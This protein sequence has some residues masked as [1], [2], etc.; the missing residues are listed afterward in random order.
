M[1]KQSST[2]EKVFQTADELLAQ[3]VRPTQQNVR[4][5]IGSGSLTTINSALN[6][7]WQ[8]LSQRITRQ[9]AHPDLPEPVVRLAS[10]AWDR[11]LAYAEQA[12][13][14]RQL[15][16]LQKQADLESSLSQTVQGSSKA[17]SDLQQQ[18]GQL[19][20]RFARMTE[21]KQS[22]EEQ[23]FKLEE[24]V[25]RLTMDL[26]QQAQQRKHEHQFH[27]AAEN[28]MDEVI[29]ARVRI[30]IQEEEIERLKRLNEKL[31]NENAK[32]R[33]V[34]SKGSEL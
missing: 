12:F 29:D 23:R 16:L 25:F 9:Q 7:W 13:K 15:A 32:L 3:G 19:L 28:Q 18:Y 8:T 24:R 6:D 31:T 27:L 14:E 11:A 34:L 22:A 1:K 33:Q 17:L 21:E 30:K 10:Q 2:R 26:E 4:D 5:L 20:E